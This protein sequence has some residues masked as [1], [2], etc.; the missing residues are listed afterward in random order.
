MDNVVTPTQAQ[1]EFFK[2]IKKVNED[3]RPILVK[4]TKA[5]EKG[6]VIIGEDDWKAIQEKLH[7][8]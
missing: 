7:Q 4:P 6:V 5:G 3:R 1:K 2:L 8:K